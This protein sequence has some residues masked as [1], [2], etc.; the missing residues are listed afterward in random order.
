M[1]LS[2]WRVYYYKVL[3]L[4][5]KRYKMASMEHGRSFTGAPEPDFRQIVRHFCSDAKLTRGSKIE[6]EHG[7]KKA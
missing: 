1:A 2:S 3:Y 6:S 5:R 4:I 7:G